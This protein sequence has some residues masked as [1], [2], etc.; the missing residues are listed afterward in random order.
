MSKLKCNKMQAKEIAKM[1]KTQFGRKVRF[2]V[3]EVKVNTSG[4]NSGC[5]TVLS[6]IAK[7]NNVTVK[8]SGTGLVIIVSI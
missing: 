8:R 3:Y 6:K 4:L 5:I 1:L 7:T 2:G